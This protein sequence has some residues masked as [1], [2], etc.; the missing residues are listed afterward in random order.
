MRQDLNT[1]KD[2]EKTENKTSNHE[3]QEPHTQLEEILSNLD[4][5]LE[6]LFK[7]DQ[8]IIPL[9]NNENNNK[10]QFR[11]K[12]KRE[13][14]SKTK[15]QRKHRKMS[16]NSLKNN[17]IIQYNNKIPVE[18]WMINSLRPTKYYYNNI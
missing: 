9:E 3:E 6:D 8:Q 12:R 17:K 1:I 5:I 18:N 11:L 4:E 15:N 2:K 7:E 10:R 16:K 13:K 14:K